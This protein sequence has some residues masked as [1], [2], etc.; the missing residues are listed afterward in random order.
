[1]KPSGVLGSDFRIVALA[2][3]SLACAVPGNGQPRAIDTVR[4]TITVHVYKAG[5]LSAFGHD[6]QISAPVARGAVDAE[7]RKVE[8]HV[9]AGAL[10]VRDPKVSDKDR[11]EIQAT[12]L[13]SDV[14]DAEKQ[15]EIGFQST[16]AESAGPGSW[17]VSG[18]LTLHGQT[19]PVSMDVH[20]KDGH[21]AGTCR[22]KYGDFGI[23]PVKAAGG[24][25][26]VKDEVEIEF[27]IQLA[28]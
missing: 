20:E 26:R 18:N 8:L 4:S 12:M 19:R 25:V 27:D 10:R 1:M 6:H 17:K 21:Y 5:L 9:N 24:A 28:R 16:G 13:G 23:K 15:K 3:F 2:A 7:G 11:D 22:F 14:L